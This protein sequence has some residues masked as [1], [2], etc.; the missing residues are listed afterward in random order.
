MRTRAAV[1]WWL[2]WHPL[3]SVGAGAFV[4]A[5]VGNVLL[6]WSVRAAMLDGGVSRYV[7]GPLQALVGGGTAYLVAIAALPALA[8]VGAGAVVGGLLWALEVRTVNA[9]ADALVEGLVRGEGDEFV[10]RRGHGSLPLV[11]ANRRYDLSSVRCGEAGLRVSVDR[12]HLDERR[13]EHVR[14]VDVPYAG[15]AAVGYDGDAL[16]VDAREG[17]HAFGADRDPVE[18]RAAIQSH[19]E[20][21]AGADPATR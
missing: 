5:V 9:R 6:T 15:M 17:T 12:L 2:G 21:A 8:A 1:R 10:L 3:A 7:G 14:D 4:G 11:D 19:R 16:V 18:L 20:R 13:V